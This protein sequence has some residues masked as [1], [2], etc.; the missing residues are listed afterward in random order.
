MAEPYYSRHM[1]GSVGSEDAA[2]EMG[3]Q[4]VIPIAGL[5]T[6]LRPHTYVRPKPLLSVAGKQILTHIVDQLH[7]LPV[8]DVTFIHGHLGE[9][10]REWAAEHCP[11][12]ARFVEQTELR[13]QAHAIRLVRDVIDR[14]TVIIFGD[15]IFKA[16]LASLGMGGEDGRL[17]VQEV[18]DPRRFGIA[19]LEGDYVKRLVEKPKEPVGNLAVVGIYYVRDPAHLMRAIDRVIERDQ[20]IGGEFY[21]ADALQQ[22]IEDGVRF[23]VSPVEVWADCGTVPA[24]LDTNRFLLANGHS[25]DPE[26]AQRSAIVQPVYVDPTAELIDSVIGPNVSIGPNVRIVR[27]IVE[28][29]IVNEGAQIERSVLAG[30]LIGRRAEVRDLHGRVNVADDSDVEAH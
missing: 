19:V 4:V 20:Q 9:Q 15:T 10:V 27:S 24:L 22:M 14:P 8:D 30:S 1:L 6:R 18:E 26:R 28:D 3:L 7:G 5:G 13:G 23:R 29:S 16:D 11:F 25:R 21:L 12:P 17:F 2:S